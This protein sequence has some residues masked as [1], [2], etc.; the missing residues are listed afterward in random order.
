MSPI[1]G[2]AVL[3]DI[4][5]ILQQLSQYHHLTEEQRLALHTRGGSGTPK[6][7]RSNEDAEETQKDRRGRFA[8]KVM[9]DMLRGC[10]R[11]S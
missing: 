3:K 11:M 5:G 6:G 9:D 2:E 7:C 4:E 8:T 10:Y 1:E